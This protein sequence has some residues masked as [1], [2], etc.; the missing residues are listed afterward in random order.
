[1][2]NVIMAANNNSMAA[3]A[4]TAAVTITHDDGA[5]ATDANA[6]ATRIIVDIDDDGEYARSIGDNDGDV[7]NANDDADDADT[8]ASRN[9]HSRTRLRRSPIF[10]NEFAVYV[11]NGEEMADSIAGKY[12]FSNMGQVSF[13][14]FRRTT[15]IIYYTQLPSCILQHYC[16]WWLHA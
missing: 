4:A 6:D 9:L 13:A 8:Y 5:L 1:M 12:G 11:P 14:R 10:Q 15:I 7:N 3:G 16:S 2:N